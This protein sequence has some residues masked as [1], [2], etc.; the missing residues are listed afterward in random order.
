MPSTDI[1][2]TVMRKSLTAPTAAISIAVTAVATPV[3]KRPDPS[4]AQKPNH[5]HRLLN[6]IGRS[7]A[8]ETA[9]LDRSQS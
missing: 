7:R 8:R 4:A 6:T 2:V 5:R 9:S 1:E 3:D